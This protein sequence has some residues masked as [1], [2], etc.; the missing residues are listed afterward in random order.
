M[1]LF[2]PKLLPLTQVRAH[3]IVPT[4]VS[5]TLTSLAFELV[6]VSSKLPELKRMPGLKTWRPSVD[7]I[8]ATTFETY[9]EFMNSSADSTVKAK[10]TP[11]HWPPANVE[12][13][14]LDRRHVLPLS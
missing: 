10:M 3:S 2:L 14:H 12:T 8:A 1:R 7:R 6:D 5:G 13:F 9:K 4:A 11:G